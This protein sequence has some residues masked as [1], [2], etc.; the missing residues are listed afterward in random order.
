MRTISWLLILLLPLSVAAQS[1][2]TERKETA[3]DALL[4][5]DEEEQA[6]AERFHAP[7]GLPVAVHDDANEIVLHQEDYVLGFDPDTRVA[8]W[9][10]YRLTAEHVAHELNRVEYFRADPR[11]ESQPGISSTPAD[12]V[13]PV[14]DQGHLV[15]SAD[16]TRSEAAMINTYIQTNMA[17]QHDRFNQHTW[18]FLEAFVR[19]WAEA[20][21]LVFITTGS[22]FDQDGDGER[23]ADADKVPITASNDRIGVPTAFF[24]ILVWRNESTGYLET[25]TL[26]LTH[27]DVSQR[28]KDLP[29]FL[30]ASC[31]RTI[32]EVEAMTGHDFFP[33][34]PDYKER[35]VEAYRATAIWDLPD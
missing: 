27:E 26:V 10:V 31:I 4:F 9:A 29:Q 19:D 3:Y 21:T 32:D 20:R 6:E 14:Y 1:D 23:D 5:L 34:L 2:I 18:R 12:Y 7:W 33:E 35:A 30:E 16:M 13:E 15:P 25:L 24:K 11:L 17:P 22:I 28:K 8:S